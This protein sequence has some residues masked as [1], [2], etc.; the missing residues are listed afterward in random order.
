MS[1]TYSRHSLALLLASAPLI[2]A[3]APV[4]HAQ[5]ANRQT[6]DLPSQPLAVSLRA[7]ATAS[8]RNVLAPA[9]LVDGVMAP[10]LKGS[11]TADEAVAA[12]LSGSG[13]RA[14]VTGSGLIVEPVP[15]MA[16]AGDDQPNPEIV[17]SGSRIRGAPVASPVIRLDREG[18]RSKGQATLADALRTL[19]QNFG[20]GQNPG[21]GLNVPEG[22]GADL[23][24][25]SS[26]NLR[27]LGSDATLTLLNG[28]RLSY[29]GFKQSIDISVIPLGAVGR[30]EVVPDGS[31]A[32]FGSDAVAGVVN[33]ILRRD[34]NGLETGARIA[35]TS[36]GGDF[37][38][39]YNVTAG[40]TWRGGSLLA[41]YE[42][43]TNSFLVSSQRDFA[44][45]RPNVTILPHMRHHS[46]LGS[47]RQ[48]IVPGLTF[49]LDGTFTKRWSDSY[50][51]R[52]L[53]GD[54]SAS[55]VNNYQQNRS[56]G[57]APSLDLAL[58][59]DWQISLAANYG[60]D[61]SSFRTDIVNGT[62]LTNA[63]SGYYR[64]RAKAIELSGNGGLFD[65]PGGR[66]K[67][68]LGAGYRQIDFLRFAGTGS[69]QNI[70][71]SLNDA[72]GFAELSLPVAR[73]VSLSAAG[74]Y[75][76]YRGVR[77]VVTPKFG[78]IVAPTPDI[79]LKG[80]WGKSFRAPTLYQQYQSQTAILFNIASVG[81]SGYPA[82]T[83]ALVLLG[84]NQRVKP[85]RSTNWSGTIEFHPRAVPGFE[86]DLSYFSVAYR[87]WIVTPLPSFTVA[88]ANP[89]Y[90]NR[91]T[92]NPSASAQT[93][94]IAGAGTFLNLSS[95]AY[96]P[97]KVAA[98]V[99]DSNVNAG[100]QNVRGVDLLVRYSG[101]AGPGTI[102]G[103]LDTAYITST[104]Q[105]GPGL[106]VTRLAGS[107]FNPPHWRVRGDLGW[108]V[109]P[110]TIAGAVTYL[111]PV[112]DNRTLTPVKVRGMTPVDVTL[113]YQAGTGPLKGL[114]ITLSVQNLFNA[115]PARIATSI[116]SDSA[117]DSTNYSPLG[118]VLSLSV[119]KK[120]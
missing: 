20:G 82:G 57:L 63:G 73:G 104:Q 62:T 114:D 96:D 115:K 102:S 40:K 9:D 98:I 111:G 47:L 7:I 29:N 31:S 109:G 12:L 52:N 72:Y 94:L 59:G 36:D 84:G 41:A 46:A 74:R 93:T 51:P 25:G 44:A 68:A 116:Y 100:R 14:R 112:E 18:I 32:L 71:R 42:Y 8:G 37:S 23:G 85:E 61:R 58:A 39:L 101:M 83:T 108:T 4:A 15:P 1:I 75:E 26:V 60:E 117:F 16:P 78:L 103:S 80:S 77:Q 97:T 35:G 43:G 88:L 38:Q 24:G 79:T 107:I 106:P 64:N 70:D 17:I 86:V 50:Y 67:L 120:W 10:A 54:L 53:A 11:F 27:G 49:S 5:A 28:H 118:R 81:G 3:F 95:G 105:I 90:A 119:S 92:A 48:E 21:I 6:Y 110:L 69:V 33:I 66:A 76:D 113:R 34:L 13:L 99:D 22:S 55:R 19:P 87:D 89:I 2:P 30:V 91:V 65:L 45:I 56:W